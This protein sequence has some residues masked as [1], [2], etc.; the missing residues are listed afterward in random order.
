MKQLF[1]SRHVDLGG[2]AKTH[3][4]GLQPAGSNQRTVDIRLQSLFSMINCKQF[5]KFKRVKIC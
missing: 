2:I 4:E 1:L 5:A 3:K